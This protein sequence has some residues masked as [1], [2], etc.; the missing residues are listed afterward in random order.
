MAQL[1]RVKFDKKG[2]QQHAEPRLRP[3]LPRCWPICRA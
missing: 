3:S 1:R 2:E